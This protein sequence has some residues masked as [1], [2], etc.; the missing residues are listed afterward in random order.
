MKQEHSIL[1]WFITGYV[2][3]VLGIY[4]LFELLMVQR[5]YNRKL[6]YRD[7]IVMFVLL[8]VVFITLAVLAKQADIVLFNYLNLEIR[9]IVFVNLAVAIL[10]F[11]SKLFYNYIMTKN[12]KRISEEFNNSRFSLTF[13]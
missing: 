1:H 11:N 8:L 7:L 5:E 3:G 6:F 12:L 13:L 2:H 9:L 4:M 10:A